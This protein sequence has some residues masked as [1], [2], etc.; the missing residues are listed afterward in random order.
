MNV[1]NLQVW[2]RVYKEQLQCR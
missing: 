1:S 2:H